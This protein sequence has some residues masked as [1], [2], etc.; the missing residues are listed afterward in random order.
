MAILVDHGF[1]GIIL[2]VLLHISIARSALRIRFQSGAPFSGELGA[3]AAAVGTSLVVYWVNAQ[4]VNVT[5]AEV[6]V[7]IAALAGALEWMAN[8]TRQA[9]VV[10]PVAEKAPAD[11]GAP[12]LTIPSARSE[13]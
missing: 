10:K 12:D 3:Y 7:W 13:R 1:V 9:E 11:Y 6:V 8:A 5:K 4:F 2:F